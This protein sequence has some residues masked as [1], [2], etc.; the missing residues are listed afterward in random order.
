MK[1][2]KLN[3]KKLVIVIIALIFTIMFDCFVIYSSFFK[4]NASNKK[5]NEVITEQID[6]NLTE[7][8]MEKVINDFG[9]TIEG[10]IE[11]NYI[12]TGCIMDYDKAVNSFENKYEVVCD[13]HKI[14]EDRSLYLDE[15]SIRGKKVEY[16]YGK[17]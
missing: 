7:K 14:K 2:E 17:K 4:V 8:E 15:C 6:I 5:N 10:M 13:I 9:T 16:S 3:K 12:N 1:K 11:V